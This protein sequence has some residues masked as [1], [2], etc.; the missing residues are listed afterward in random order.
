MNKKTVFGIFLLIQLLTVDSVNSASPRECEEADRK[1]WGGGMDRQ[2][3]LPKLMIV[4][5]G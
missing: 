5:I 1:C 3:H 2:E 4:G